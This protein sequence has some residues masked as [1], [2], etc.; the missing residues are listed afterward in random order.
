MQSIEDFLSTQGCD[1]GKLQDSI[2]SQTAISWG[3]M[4]SRNHDQDILLV[5][6]CLSGSEKAWTDFYCRFEPLVR[7]QA[8]RQFWLGRHEIEDLTQTVFV[9]LMSDL[10]TWDRAH[11]LAGFVSMIAKRECIDEYRRRRAGKRDCATDPVDHHDGGEEGYRIPASNCENQEEELSQ[12]ERKYL[13]EL[14]FPN[15]QERCR[16][17][18][19][20]RF[21]QEL[22]YKEITVILGGSENT[23]TV[24]ARRCLEELRAIIDEL[25]R[26]GVGP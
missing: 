6:E 11:S 16:D 7:K 22:P 21:Y 14:A 18:L 19:G 25:M 24:Q 15:L 20:M 1:Y 2:P 13:I 5:Q 8:R 4:G 26:K 9:A 3:L 17:L 23:L 10:N 12:A